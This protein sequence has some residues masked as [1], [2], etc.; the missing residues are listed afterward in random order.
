MLRNVQK[1]LRCVHFFN[2]GFLA[3]LKKTLANVEESTARIGSCTAGKFLIPT[4]RGCGRT[5]RLRTNRS[6]SS[7]VGEIFRQHVARL[8]SM[9]DGFYI[10]L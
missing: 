1:Q 7:R 6:G 9:D 5:R 2:C 8:C 3:E 10:V 4:F